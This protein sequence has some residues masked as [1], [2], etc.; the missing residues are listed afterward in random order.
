MPKIRLLLLK[1]LKRL[2]LFIVILYFSI[3]ILLVVSQRSLLYFPSKAINHPFKEIKFQNKDVALRLIAS[4]ENA[5]DAIIYFGGNAE[6]VY[7]SHDDF[8]H[9]FKT[10]ALYLLNYRGYGGSRGT[11][12]EKEL[13]EDALLIYD[14]LHLKH[15]NITLIGRSLGSGVAT[16]VAANRDIEKLILI[17]PF[18]SIQ[19]VA[20]EKFP[21][22]P[23]QL[24]LF[25]KYD[26]IARARD[27]KAQTLFLIAEDD[28]LVPNENSLKL[29][30]A[31]APQKVQKEI[32]KGYNHN[33]IQL[34]PLYYKKMQQ[35]L[36]AH[37]FNAR[38]KP[39]HT[40]NGD[41]GSERK[42]YQKQ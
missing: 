11:P 34:A 28:T 13:Y 39:I 27:I 38:S 23:M 5:K 20:Q 14:A 19:A 1:L 22:Y 15:K 30:D 16:Y 8:S 18:D 33:N 41:V 26:S 40:P 31:F 29:Y 32:F 36:D 21:I 10:R 4:N 42:Q 2:A 9:Y 35:F 3:G 6:A 12:R 17:T 25:D 37:R 24:M 7:A